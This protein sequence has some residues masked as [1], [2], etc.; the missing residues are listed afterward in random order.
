MDFVTICLDK[1]L[2][3]VSTKLYNCSF[4][5]LYIKKLHLYN[6]INYKKKKIY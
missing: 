5:L 1:V 3:I 2:Q 6:N 4:G